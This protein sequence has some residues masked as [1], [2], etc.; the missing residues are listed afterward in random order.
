[1]AKLNLFLPAWLSCLSGP[2]ILHAAD[3]VRSNNPPLASGAPAE[4]LPPGILGSPGAAGFQWREVARM[5]G[6]SH[7]I[8]G[9][10]LDGRFFV[11]GGLT[12]LQNPKRQHAYDEV[13]ELT[14]QTWKWRIAAKLSGKRIYCS[15]AAFEGK[16]WVIEGDVLEVDGSRRTVRTVELYD[17]KTG[18][19]TAGPEPEFPRPM[20]LALSAA[21]RLYVMGNAAGETHLPGKMESIG[22]GETVW[23]REPDGPEGMGP[24]A[25]A[26]L[27]GNLYV[28][29]PGKGLAIFNTKATAWDLVSWPAI[30]RS[31]EVA[32]YRDEI[33]LMGGRAGDGR[34]TYIFN[35]ATRAW[36][37]GPPLPQELSWGAGGV[38]GQELIV[39][40]GAGGAGP[41][42]Y[43]SDATYALQRTHPEGK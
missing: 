40:G 15:T 37:A 11:A 5:P 30:P 12:E 38:V 28:A 39:A 7:D 29:I 41:S 3:Y 27:D 1:M 24:L 18:V 32:A 23:R 9:A 22:P 4:S 31:C 2:A 13:W 14:P 10:E 26:A 20:P 35:P 6:T 8:S 17:P 21:G 34:H 16:I 36:Q 42:G 19:V 25:G 43:Y 33:W